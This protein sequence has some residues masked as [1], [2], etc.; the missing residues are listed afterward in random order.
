VVP[1]V[2]VNSSGEQE[3]AAAWALQREL[4][5]LKGELEAL[6]LWCLGL[7]QQVAQ[8]AVVQ[9]LSVPA[10]RRGLTRFPVGAT[11]ELGDLGERMPPLGWVNE[12]SRWASD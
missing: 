5:Q 11:A 8:L 2:P 1:L 7:E 4:R 12:R 3:P 10:A 9:A 6:R